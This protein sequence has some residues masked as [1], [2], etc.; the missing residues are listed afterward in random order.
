MQ[1]IAAATGESYILDVDMTCGAGGCSV[2]GADPIPVANYTNER[3]QMAVARLGDLADGTVKVSPAW[4]SYYAGRLALMEE[5]LG[6]FGAPA[7]RSPPR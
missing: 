3:W 1:G 5:F 6:R 7:D 4:Q 2:T